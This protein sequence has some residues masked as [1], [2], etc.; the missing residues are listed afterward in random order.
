MNRAARELF[1]LYLGDHIAAGAG[2]AA[3]SR[4]AASGEKHTEFGPPLRALA[5]DIE[6]DLK[7][8]RE[9]AET[10]GASARTPVKERLASLAEKLGRLKLNKR[11]LVRSPLSRVYELELLQAAVSGKRG[12][13][14]TLLELEPSEPALT[15]ADLEVLLI[16]ADAQQEQIRSLHDRASRIA[17][18]R[19]AEHAVHAPPP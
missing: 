6:A 18:G 9:I 16:R 2:G 1:H 7:R 14:Q 8:L 10:L 19:G 12:L 15:R 11:V 17:F 4:R 13:W 3:L 5:E